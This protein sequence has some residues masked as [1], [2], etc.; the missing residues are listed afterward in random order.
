MITIMAV[1]GLE[2][3]KGKDIFMILWRVVEPTKQ[4]HWGERRIRW[5]VEAIL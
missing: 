2:K 4:P 1:P 5:T 3:S